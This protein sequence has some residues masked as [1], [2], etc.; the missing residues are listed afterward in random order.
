MSRGKLKVLLLRL[1]IAVG[2]LEDDGEAASQKVE[3]ER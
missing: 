3:Q 1:R 2:E